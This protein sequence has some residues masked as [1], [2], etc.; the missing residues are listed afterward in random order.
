MFKQPFDIQMTFN[1]RLKRARVEFTAAECFAHWKPPRDLIARVESKF[2]EE[3][4][5]GY[6]ETYLIFHKR[7]EEFWSHIRGL[8]G[9]LDPA[10]KIKFTL[11]QGGRRY[12]EIRLDRDESHNFRLSC[13]FSPK[14]I[15]TISFSA[16][17]FN[18]LMLIDRMDASWRADRAQLKFLY[19]MLKNGQSFDAVTLLPQASAEDNTRSGFALRMNTASHYA[20]LHVFDPSWFAS[21]AS[22]R[23]LFKEARLAFTKLKPAKEKMIFLESHS[24][25]KILSLLSKMQAF[26]FQMPYDLLVAYDESY[27]LNANLLTADKTGEFDLLA[28]SL[29]K[30]KPS[31][32]RT[33]GDILQIDLDP[34]RMV[35]TVVG[36]NQDIAKLGP[37][38][39]LSA[40][41]EDIQ[42]AGV[43]VGFEERVE[44]LL[45]LIHSGR[46][47][48]GYVAA[49]GRAAA[50]GKTL[51]FELCNADDS[52]HKEAVDIRERQNHQVV[53]KGSLV[54]EVRYT[55]GLAGS[56]VDG[57]TFYALGS[58][59]SLGMS[60]GH[61]VSLVKDQQ[62][63]ATQ[64]GL[65][66]VEG[67]TISC[68]AAYVHKGSINLAS[69]NLRFEGSV[70]IE[71]D[72]ES[73]A[74]VD[75]DGALIV[76]GSIDGAKVSCSGDLE[77]L[78]GVNTGKIGYLHVG[79]N[80]RLGFVENSIVHVK[81]SLSVQR[82]ITHSLVISGGLIHV[83]DE[84][85]GVIVGGLLC[86]WQ[87]I[88]CAKFGMSQGTVTQCRLG[89]QHRTEI[90]LQRLATRQK[91]FQAAADNNLKSIAIFE[92][93]G[94]QLS[95]DQQKRYDYVKKNAGRYVNILKIIKVSI[96]K[97]S[98]STDYNVDATLVVKNILDKNSMIWVCGK[99][100]PVPTNMKGVLV[101]KHV[102]DG[103]LDLGEVAKFREQHPAA[104]VA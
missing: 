80:A 74:T 58:A 14:K 84:S 22:C 43:T 32:Q 46:N 55:D 3:R 8:K 52:L 20:S 102:A 49:I 79:G 30:V 97:A 100:I 63:Y 75:I 77:V 54:A 6:I 17:L 90:R 92:K 34:S 21:E 40:L 11:G 91:F 81:R 16:F 72:I 70:V 1:S 4:D 28:R 27:R 94:L 23:S 93:P 53:R 65:L 60:A 29:A 48:L 82:S 67:Q 85:N 88:V 69:G 59:A 18:V 39:T 37:T 73:G 31:H 33:R 44:G 68:Q 87:A 41:T 7:F 35:A 51:S 5:E 50:A 95:A 24:L 10:R 47:A 99:K 78:G 103:I 104:I 38:L 12:P 83:L 26:G 45:D 9:S 19:L 64:D 86:A 101:S 56:T 42:R 61:G 98:K 13:K 66:V 71:G 25:D 62:F 15:S 36:F 2:E 76:K 89:S 57:R 96:A